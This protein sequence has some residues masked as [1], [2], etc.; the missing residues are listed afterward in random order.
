MEAEVVLI[1][2]RQS[3]GQAKV[4]PAIVLRAMP[5]FHDL[6]LCG[7]STQLRHS[8]LN[9]DEMIRSID[10]DFQDSGLDRESLIRLGWLMVV[11]RT[12]IIGTIG[13]IS[14]ERHQR[15]LRNL[16]SY[17]IVQA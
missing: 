6:L 16:A 17:L 15:L 4:R 8:T 1:T 10:T 5:P 14:A 12:E 11:P 7:I 2:L 13:S 3:N 9:F